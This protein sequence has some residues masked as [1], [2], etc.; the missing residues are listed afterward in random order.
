MSL[1]KKKI[2]SWFIIS[3]WTES[4]RLAIQNSWVCGNMVNVCVRVKKRQISLS[5]F[6]GLRDEWF[7]ITLKSYEFDFIDSLIGMRKKKVQLIKLSDAIDRIQY[8]Y[9]MDRLGMFSSVSFCRFW[10]FVHDSYSMLLWFG[11]YSSRLNRKRK[12]NE[13]STEQQTFVIG[14]FELYYI[15]V[16]AAN[17]SDTNIVDFGKII[18]LRVFFVITI[19]YGCDDLCRKHR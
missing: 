1:N 14:A 5:Q 6:P 8:I 18:K 15:N 12:K 16:Y 4:Y 17:M 3:K 2:K 13:S 9:L 7:V 19:V 11:F 10:W